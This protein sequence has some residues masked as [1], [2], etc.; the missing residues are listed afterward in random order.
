S[1]YLE[2]MLFKG[3]S[4]RPT[5]PE[6]SEAI[7]GAG[8]ALNAYTTRELTCYWNNM[9]FERAATGV[10]VLA[11]M[12]QRSLL[13]QEEL[14][15]ERTV[16]QQEIRRGHDAP[17]SRAAELM[18]RAV[19]GDQ[20]IGWPVTGSIETVEG[21]TRDDFVSH[22]ERFYGAENTVLS[23]AGN[24]THEWVTEAAAEWFDGLRDG[25]AR[26]PSAAEHGLPEEPIIIE[27]REIEQT[28][29]RLAVQ[30][31]ARRD[32]DRYALALLHTVLG[33]G[34]SSR[35]F[36]EV[37][38]RRG[39]AYSVASGVAQHKDIGSFIVSAG[40]SRDQ[41]E[42]ALQVIVGEL[43]RA[44][45][46]PVSDEELQ[47]AK[48]FAAGTFRLSMETPMALGQH[49]GSQLLQDGEIELPGDTVE[50]LRAVEA[51][52]MQAVAQRLFGGDYA[53]AVVGPSASADRLSAILAA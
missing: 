26:T 7:E 1:H 34:M 32:P 13:D 53:L 41:Q 37:R 33:R 49:F 38:E 24:V 47:R 31:P 42:E 46:E 39:L 43:Q 20:P 40:V 18:V 10:E 6:I 21:L 15:R 14:D 52:D 44:A 22:V 45:D 28:N 27:E 4:T 23:V 48:D 29:I 9:P 19:Y 35:L 30:G 12:I 17:A 5:A 2:H 11:D 50:R 36:Q 3:T 8:G 25:A 51:G 16:V